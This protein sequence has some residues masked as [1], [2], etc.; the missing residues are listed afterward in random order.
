MS[1]LEYFAFIKTLHLLFASLWTGGIILTVVINR[2]LRRTMPATEATKTLGVIGR[3]IQ[4]TMRYSLYLAIVT[5]LLLLLT[6]GVA[7]TALFDPIFYTTRFGAFL[8]GKI[9]SVL[10]VLSL[11]PLHSRLGEKIYKTN[12]GADYR[13]LRLGILLV[14]WATLGFTIVA[15]IAGTWLRLS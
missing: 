11:L 4:K 10:L 9:I 15:I 7:F 13:R 1:L 3:S 14:G 6:R 2:A 12:G 8:L 5:G